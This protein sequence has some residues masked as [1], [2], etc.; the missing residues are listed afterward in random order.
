MKL[1]LWE[2]SKS[3]DKILKESLK[4]FSANLQDIKIFRKI[5]KKLIFSNTAL[6]LKRN[7]TQFFRSY[8][9]W[10]EPFLGLA[11]LWSTNMRWL[12]SRQPLRLCLKCIPGFISPVQ[13]ARPRECYKFTNFWLVLFNAYWNGNWPPYF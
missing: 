8:C 1:I 6:P 11:S 10:G 7:K 3:F 5:F 9:A 4:K 2:V 13:Y 12:G